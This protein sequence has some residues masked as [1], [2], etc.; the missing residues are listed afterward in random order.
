[1][2][3]APPVYTISIRLPQTLRES[4]PTECT[5]NKFVV[6]AVREKV[7]GFHFGDPQAMRWLNTQCQLWGITVPTARE[8]V[9][10]WIESQ[11]AT[12]NPNVADLAG[13]GLAMAGDQ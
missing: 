13:D 2:K 11:Q 5:V 3:P 7:H 1:M 10:C 9:K 6:Q 4:I 12:P 8:L